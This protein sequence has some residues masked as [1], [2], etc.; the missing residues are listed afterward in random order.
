MAQCFFTVHPKSH[1]LLRVGTIKNKS[2]KWVG[3]CLVAVAL[4]GIKNSYDYENSRFLSHI[5]HF[6]TVFVLG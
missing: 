2:Q 5:P 4:V 6:G 1:A 3:S